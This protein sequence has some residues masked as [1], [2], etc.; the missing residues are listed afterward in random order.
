[1]GT[2]HEDKYIF[3]IISRSIL[4]RMRNALDRSCRRNQT[5]IL[6]SI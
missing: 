5:H 1:M 6:Y 3:F 2:L 4:L